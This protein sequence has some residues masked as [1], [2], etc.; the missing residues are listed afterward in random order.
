MKRSMSM[1]TLQLLVI[2]AALVFAILGGI[3]LISGFT[4]EADVNFAIGELSMKAGETEKI[5]L[6]Y[7]PENGRRPELTFRSSN[8][9]VAKVTQ[10]GIVNAVRAGECEISCSTPN[11]QE[12]TIPVVVKAKKIKKTIFLTFE[13]GPSKEATPAVLDVLKKYDAKATFFVVGYQ[14]EATPDILKRTV[15]EGHTIGIHTYS[16]DYNEIYKSEEAYLAD[17]DRAEKVIRDL[18]G[19]ECAYWRFPGGGNNDIM[20]PDTMKS[21]MNKLHR[22]G[23]TEIDWNS[24]TDDAVGVE[25]TTEEMVKKGIATIDIHEVP[26]VLIHDA[27]TNSQAAEITEGILKHYSEKGYKFKGLNDYTGPELTIGE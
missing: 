16:N 21:V 19:I 17:F 2:A 4:A 5:P 10:D 18:T 3:I 23:Y 12:V 22:R 11:G 6:E 13:D 1:R 9:G 25:M 20:G 14:V 7:D 26:I 8:N 24:Y 27:N 15:L